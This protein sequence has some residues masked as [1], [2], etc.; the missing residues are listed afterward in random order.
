MG[1]Q[2]HTFRRGATYTWRKR[3]PASLGG[4][5]FQISL[6]TT[7]PLIG[8]RLATILCAESCA[9]VDAMIHDG[10]NKEDARKL[11]V[12]VIAREHRK[13]A[14]LRLSETENPAAVAWERAKSA[15]W[16]M[17]KALTLLAERGASGRH[18]TDTDRVALQTEGRSDSDIGMLERILD[19]EARSYAEDPRQGLNN[20]SF[21]MMRDTFGRDQ[22][23]SLELM[24]GRQIY[25]R[26]RGAVL[27][28]G[29]E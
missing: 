21:S 14:V 5:V 20:R 24:H 1:I 22:F 29:S 6:R 18:L 17:G 13:I 3:L 4:G 8:R 25:Y 19:Q 16:A 7:N 26:G 2:M 23:S 27:L 10:L 11:L 12:A 9:V 15:D 28:G